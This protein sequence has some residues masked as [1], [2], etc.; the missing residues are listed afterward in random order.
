MRQSQGRGSVNEAIPRSWER[1]AAGQ[2]LSVH[3]FISLRLSTSTPREMSHWPM[4]PSRCGA[5]EQPSST[6]QCSSRR[7]RRGG[8]RA[9]FRSTCDGCPSAA[10]GAR[11]V[12][13][14]NADLLFDCEVGVTDVDCAIA[15]SGYGAIEATVAANAAGARSLVDKDP[16]KAVGAFSRRRLYRRGQPRRREHGVQAQG[17]AG[18]LR[19]YTTTTGHDFYACRR[20]DGVHMHRS[21]HAHAHDDAAARRHRRMQLQS[22]RARGR[23]RCHV[24]SSGGS[25]YSREPIA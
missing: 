7:E 17:G 18:V 20:L 19:R 23:R 8:G 22:S 21:P 14:D 15:E 13:N 10:A 16:S 2:C 1:S 25:R 4:P 11:L 3:P 6:F 12:P 24:S 9:Q 5:S